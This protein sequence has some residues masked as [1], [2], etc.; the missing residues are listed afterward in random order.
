M[1][2]VQFES[3]NSKMSNGERI[4]CFL[5]IQ[6]KFEHSK[7]NSGMQATIRKPLH[8]W[9]ALVDS[10]K[11]GTCPLASTPHHQRGA[12]GGHAAAKEE[13]DNEGQRQGIPR[14]GG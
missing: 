3:P 4:S 5:K 1:Q 10:G 6:K 11:V 7:V 9:V 12:S 2:A 14:G 13:R 8:P